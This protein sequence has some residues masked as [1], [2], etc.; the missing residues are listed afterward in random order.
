MDSN[1]CD[2]NVNGSFVSPNKSH[3]LRLYFISINEYITHFVSEGYVV[4][5]NC[6]IVVLHMISWL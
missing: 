5:L 3:T 4:V 2:S 1:V 6:F